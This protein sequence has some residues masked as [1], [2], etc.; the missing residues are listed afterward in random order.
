MPFR[1]RLAPGHY[2]LTGTKTLYEDSGKRE[3]TVSPIV[4]SVMK[5]Q[6]TRLYLTAEES[7][8]N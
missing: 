6:E 4:F 5:K 8:V 3:A 7:R 2:T 1:I